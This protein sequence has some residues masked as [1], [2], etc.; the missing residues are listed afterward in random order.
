MLEDQCENEPPC[1][2]IYASVCVFESLDKSTLPFELV[3]M[4][5][6][7]SRGARVR[8]SAETQL[9]SQNFPSVRRLIA[10]AILMMQSRCF[11][12]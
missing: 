2:G 6:V 1:V 11:Y 12:K 5:W 10:T 7:E 3:G 9:K 8:V 4:V